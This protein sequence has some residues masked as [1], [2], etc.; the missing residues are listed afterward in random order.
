VL[1]GFALIAS[2]QEQPERAAR[3]WG[4]AVELRGEIGSLLPL[5][6]REEYDRNIAMVRTA[7]GEEAFTAAWA[8]GRA[9]TMEQAIAYA[10]SEE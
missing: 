2:A 6:E 10:L 4:A 7:L 9:M 8:E 5:N 1:E 3:L